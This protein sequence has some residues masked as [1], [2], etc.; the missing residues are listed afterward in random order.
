MTGVSALHSRIVIEQAKG[1]LAQ[2][3]IVDV[4]VAFNLIRSYARRTNRRLIEVAQ[5]VVTD[6]AGMPGLTISAEQRREE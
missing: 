6:L 4:D 5:A 2:A 1:V 3:H